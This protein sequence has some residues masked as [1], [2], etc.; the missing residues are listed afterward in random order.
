M[1]IVEIGKK[2][3]LANRGALS[4]I[5]NRRTGLF[6]LGR[7]YQKKRFSDDVMCGHFH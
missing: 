4:K 6:I 2:K 5:A 7:A 3:V 1:F